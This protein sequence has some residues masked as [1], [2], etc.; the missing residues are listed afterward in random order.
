M[1]D[2]TASRLRVPWSRVAVKTGTS[3]SREKGYD[4]LVIGYLPAGSPQVAFGFVAEGAGFAGLEGIDVLQSFL[5]ALHAQ[6]GE[7]ARRLEERR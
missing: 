7:L 6:G 4:A 2:G 5:D 3:G 1:P